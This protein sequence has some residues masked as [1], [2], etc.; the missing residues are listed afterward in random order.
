MLLNVY[1]QIRHRNRSVMII[2]IYILGIRI[3]QILIGHKKKTDKP[4][5]KYPVL[6]KKE[7][8]KIQIHVTFVY[9]FILNI[10]NLLSMFELWIMSKHFLYSVIF[11][12]K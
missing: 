4:I 1:V 11:H 9:T 7:K 3:F 6:T 2:Y 8:E 5:S 12:A 10:K